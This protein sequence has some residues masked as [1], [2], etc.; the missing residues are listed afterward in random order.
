MNVPGDFVGI[1]TSATNQFKKWPGMA[2]TYSSIVYRP[3]MTMHNHDGAFIGGPFV[4]SETSH[5]RP[6]PVSRHKL[7]RA[8]HDYVISLGVPVMFGKRVTSYQDSLHEKRPCV[9]IE[10]GER[11]EADIVVAADGV[12]SKVGEA[13]GT[14]DSQAIG[15]G[16]SVYRVT[17]PTEDL[18]K[19]PFLAEQYRFQDGDMDYC[20]VFMSSEGQMIVLV[21]RELVTWLFT[22]KVNNTA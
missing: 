1:G 11:F 6:V 22:H 15:S 10:G 21:S 20:Q 12:G 8:L 7:I 18:Q 2:K 3:A 9:V 14:R 13:M 16:W 17:Y 5:W 4:L 19:D